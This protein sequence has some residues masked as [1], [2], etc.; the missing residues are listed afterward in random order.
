M[1]FDSI[2]N[3]VKGWSK[4]QRAVHLLLASLMLASIL[5]TAYFAKDYA[6]YQGYE[7]PLDRILA[8]QEFEILILHISIWTIVLYLAFAAIL[9]ITLDKQVN[10]IVAFKD[11]IAGMKNWGLGKK[12]WHL[13]IVVYLLSLAILMVQLSYDRY[14]CDTWGN[15]F[16][17]LKT[18]RDRYLALLVFS[19]YFL[20]LY[21]IFLT[22]L[23]IR[24]FRFFQR[25]DKSAT[26][27]GIKSLFRLLGLLAVI[28][29]ILILVF[30]PKHD[31]GNGI[32]RSQD[33]VLIG[34]TINLLVALL[35]LD[36]TIQLF[37][38]QSNLPRI[39]FVPI[40]LFI[41]LFMY[42]FFIILLFFL[43]IYFLGLGDI[44]RGF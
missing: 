21:V 25:A 8:E 40:K 24:H 7:S 9:F 2:L 4:T 23:I 35:T 37:Y 38:W 18:G 19:L 33:E 11:W 12:A 10:L 30:I 1:S 44:Y 13:C 27:L 32:I 20:V 28:I 34:W 16:D 42:L 22:V 5:V 31:D 39:V 43:Q 14:G 41:L 3:I 17:E 29:C 36:F 26:S 15:P 6:C